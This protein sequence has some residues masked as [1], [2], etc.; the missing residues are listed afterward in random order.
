MSEFSALGWSE[1]LG[2]YHTGGLYVLV[3]EVVV[4]RQVVLIVAHVIEHMRRQTLRLCN[5]SAASLRRNKTAAADVQPA[6][7]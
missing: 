3:H 1:A 5:I 6:K 2:R 4:G 7:M